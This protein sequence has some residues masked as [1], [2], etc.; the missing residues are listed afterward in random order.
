MREPRGSRFFVII[1]SK[2]L[3]HRQQ[4]GLHFSPVQVKAMIAAIEADDTA[5]V[6]TT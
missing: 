3:R 4:F 5:F 2:N 6:V 1:T